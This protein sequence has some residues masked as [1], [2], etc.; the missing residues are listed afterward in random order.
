MS[1][2][3]LL[4]NKNHPQIPYAYYLLAL[5]HYDQIVDEKRPNEII[6]AQELF[7]YIIDKYPD[8]DY[9]RDANFKLE[10]INEIIASKKCI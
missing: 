3:D 6:K 5:C 9:A 4:L 7:E 2:K 10:F 8:T 1:W